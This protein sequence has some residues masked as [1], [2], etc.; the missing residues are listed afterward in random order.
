MKYDAEMVR[1]K[2]ISATII[3]IFL[4]VGVPKYRAGIIKETNENIYNLFEY[5]ISMR[6]ESGT[7]T[8]RVFSFAKWTVHVF[9]NQ[10]QSPPERLVVKDAET[11]AIL[12]STAEGCPVTGDLYLLD[13]IDFCRPWKNSLAKSHFTKYFEQISLQ[14]GYKHFLL[15]NNTP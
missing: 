14:P 6:T 7:P 5:Q 4:L 13:W 1:Y 10:I 11:Q 12:Y 2:Y 9:D 15:R 3:L 8:L